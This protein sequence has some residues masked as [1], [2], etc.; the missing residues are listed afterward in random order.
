MTEVEKKSGLQFSKIIGYLHFVS[1]LACQ[2]FARKIHS[3]REVAS[4]AR[5]EMLDT[6]CGCPV[7]VNTTSFQ[8]ALSC[9]H[10]FKKKERT[11]VYYN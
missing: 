9:K 11:Y 8:A 4:D 1:R 5:L 2:I 3:T 7:R 6:V 10:F